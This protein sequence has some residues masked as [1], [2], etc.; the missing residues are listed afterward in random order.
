MGRPSLCAYRRCRQRY[1][2]SDLSRTGAV[3]VTRQL[4]ASMGYGRP[5][6]VAAR[7]DA[8]LENPG[9][10]KSEDYYLMWRHAA[11]PSG[12]EYPRPWS[13]K[14]HEVAEKWTGPALANHM[15]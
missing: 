9:F 15:R 4:P 12:A 13:R 3:W 14:V 7:N 8:L 1:Y 10:W 11:A 5:A 2:R 6:R